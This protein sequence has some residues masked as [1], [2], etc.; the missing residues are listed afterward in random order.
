MIVGNDVAKYQGDIDFGVYKNNTNFLICKATEGVGYIDPKFTSNRDESRN[1][2]IPLGFYHFARPDLGNQPDK[3][4]DYF[5]SIIGELREGKVL[6]LD[7]ECPNQIQ[8]HVDWCKKWLDRVAEKTNG[9]KALIYL[10]QAQL[11]KFDWTQVVNGG[12]GLWVAAYLKTTAEPWY[13]PQ[14]N[15]FFK[16]QWK[17]VAMQ[18]WTSTQK[19]P[20][21]V[22]NVDGDVFFGDIATFKKYGYTKPAPPPPTIDWKKKYEDEHVI[23]EAY[24]VKAE[25]D[26]QVAISKAVRE[27]VSPLLI[28]IENAKQALA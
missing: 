4:A 12:Y 2:G 21:I 19:V 17:V 5:L 10:N 25:E 3:E 28:K 11:R 6:Y 27:A 9:T 15:D 23:F 24:K 14:H 20:G 22:G 26:K 7:Y 18:Q 16:G 13:S 1:A 8:A